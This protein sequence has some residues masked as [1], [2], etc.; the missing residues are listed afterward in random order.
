M[1]SLDTLE[2]VMKIEDRFAVGMNRANSP[3][4]SA[5]PMSSPSLHGRWMIE[6]Q[7]APRLQV[8]VVLDGTPAS[9]AASRSR[10]ATRHD[11]PTCER[12]LACALLHS[13]TAFLF[14]TSFEEYAAAVSLQIFAR[15]CPPG[16][17]SGQLL[18]R[19]PLAG[20]LLAQHPV[21]I[22]T[23]KGLIV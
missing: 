12:A 13:R 17:C 19:E 20:R 6:R 2:A 14:P 15:R 4:A 21:T 3:P 23:T 5:L 7:P 16:E 9:S 11:S 22:R 18:A 8:S 1:D 10:A